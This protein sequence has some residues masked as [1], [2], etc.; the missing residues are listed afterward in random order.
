VDAGATSTTGSSRVH[1][2]PP[3]LITEEGRVRR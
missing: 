1:H 2:L 3:D